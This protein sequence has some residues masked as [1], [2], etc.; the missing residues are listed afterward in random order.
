MYT[1]SLQAWERLRGGSEMYTGYK[2]CSNVCGNAATH[3]CR[4]A[5]DE[6]NGVGDECDGCDLA[7]EGD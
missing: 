4:E 1:A 5:V 3:L 2:K 6:K 7:K